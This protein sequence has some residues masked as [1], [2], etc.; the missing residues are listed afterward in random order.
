[1]TLTFVLWTNNLPAFSSKVPVDRK[2]I[3][4]HQCISGFTQDEKRIHG[5]FK[6]A[7][8]LHDC[9]YNNTISR[10]SLRPWNS[11]WD[12]VAE[13]IWLLGQHHKAD[14]VVN[15]YAYSYGVGWGA[16]QLCKEL[17]KRGIPV[18]CV[19]ACDGVFRHPNPLMRWTSLLRR[20]LAFSP[21]IRIPAN[22]VTVVPLHQKLN[23]PQGHKIVGGKDFTGLIQEPTELYVTHQYMD[24]AGQFHDA[25]LDAAAVLSEVTL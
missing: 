13:H 7:E 21:V 8:K 25:A 1:M 18:H 11:R 17:L 9:G 4:V 5:V 16:V 12:E 14:V 15:I 2:T 24:D 6:L 22:V 19:V 3:R 23:R 10:V 20:D